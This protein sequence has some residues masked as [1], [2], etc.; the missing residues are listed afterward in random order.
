MRLVDTAGLRRKAK[1]EAG[2]EK[3]STQD[4]LRAITFAEVVLMV[5]DAT[6]P[7]ETQDLSLADLV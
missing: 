5:M 4:S 6:H 2:L 7:F 3:L 1:V